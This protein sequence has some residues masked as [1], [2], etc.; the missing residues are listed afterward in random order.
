MPLVLADDANGQRRRLSFVQRRAPCRRHRTKSPDRQNRGSAASP[1]RSWL[2]YSWAEWLRCSRK[3]N[4]DHA[5]HRAGIRS[6]SG[7]PVGR[8]AHLGD[9]QV[10]VVLGNRLAHELFDFGDSQLRLLDARAGRRAP[11]SRTHRRRPPEKT[12]AA[13]ADRAVS[14]SPPTSQK[15]CRRSATM[16]STPRSSPRTYQPMPRSIIASQRANA[17]WNGFRLRSRHG[18]SSCGL[19]IKALSDGTERARK[20]IGRDHRKRHAQRHR[21]EQELAHARHEDQR[22]QHQ[23]RAQR[24]HQFRHGDFARA[25]KAASVGSTPM[26]R[27]R[28]VFSRQMIAL[29]TNG[30]IASARP[31]NVMTLIGL[32]GRVQADDRRHHRKRNRQ[33]GDHRHSPLAQEQQDDQR[34]KDGSQRAFLNQGGNRI[35]NV[36]RLVHDDLQVDV[37]LAQP[38]LHIRQRLAQRVRRRSA[39]WRRLVDRPAHRPAGGR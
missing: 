5:V 39:C 30:P 16:L 4:F 19:S 20:Q 33:H 29:S 15:Q 2:T 12:P 23:E 34:T 8:D 3:L 24:R 9:D 6:V 7:R 17:R 36:D 10:Q 31:A 35:A 27:W 11:Q 28:C 32:A 14:S 26:L 22:R 38:R 18:A 21:L 13:A 1:C 25:R 37:R